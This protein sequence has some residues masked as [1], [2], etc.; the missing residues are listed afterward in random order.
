MPEQSAP[1]HLVAPVNPNESTFKSTRKGLGKYL[2]FIYQGSAGTLSP[3]FKFISW[4]A[5]LLTILIGASLIATFTGLDLQVVKPYLT[6]KVSD[7]ENKPIGGASVTLNNGVQTETDARGNYTINNL[8]IA[9]YTITVTADG[10]EE[11]STDTNIGRTYLNYANVV[12]FNLPKAGLA[13]VS[14]KLIAPEAGYQFLDDQIEVK[15]V[16]FAVSTDGSFV[17]QDIS[18]GPNSLIVRS[19]NFQDT[20]VKFD[21]F[22]GINPPL[23]D[24]PLLPAG[25]IVGDLRSYVRGDTVTD[26]TIE[27]TEVPQAQIMRENG[28]FAVI[29]MEIGRI[30][31][32]RIS[33]PDYETREY[34]LEIQQ[35]QN[36]IE[37]FHI[38]EKGVLPF[39]RQIENEYQLFASNLDG[40]NA[41]Q[42]TTGDNN[43]PYAE[44]YDK[45]NDIIYYLSTRDGVNNKLGGRALLAYAVKPGE[46][47]PQRLTTT[48][49]NIGQVTP[50]FAA[51]QLLN[52]TGRQVNQ[53]NERTLEIMGLDGG[54]RQTVVTVTGAT[55]DDMSLSADGKVLYYYVQDPQDALTGLYR[56]ATDVISAQK[57]FDMPDL[58]IYDISYDGDRILFS[59]TN[60]DT[61][62][63]E[64]WI[65]N[66][67]TNQRKLIKSN[68]GNSTHYQ[69]I[70]GSDNLVLFLDFQEGGSN[71]YQLNIRD[72]V[73]TRLTMF[74]GTEGVES[75]YQQREFALYQTNRGLYILDPAKPQS[76]VLVTS[77]FARFTGNDF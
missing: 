17:L 24:I 75:V 63:N 36:R 33:H 52:Y 15:G 23:S 54:N 37:G 35:G 76:S 5:I 25:D 49:T 3:I 28:D 9:T 10:F 62:L 20:T 4:I 14:G 39:L 34:S 74:S 44:Y 31:T 41:K 73:E 13:T 19:A 22:A 45:A 61:D 65:Y 2:G 55:I 30:Y 6:G 32:I 29:D 59:A 47:N 57:L 38:V 77:E 53:T 40:E 12:N 58:Q 48:T 21:L 16:F 8:D 68:T 46:G 50:N 26:L 67:T 69:F 60:D 71:V 51:G 27:I 11:T 56:T 42:L 1:V 43:D 70:S 72:N 7:T 64:L 18:T 66:F